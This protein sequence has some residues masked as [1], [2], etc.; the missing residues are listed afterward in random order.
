MRTHQRIVRVGTSAGAGEWHQVRSLPGWRTDIQ[1]PREPNCGF[2]DRLEGQDSSS[3]K[4]QPSAFCILFSLQSQPPSSLVFTGI[5]RGPESAGIMGS[6]PS[7]V[8][9]QLCDNL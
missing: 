5:V 1:K 6:Q 4:V 8:A 2:R 7:A 3:L 9:Y